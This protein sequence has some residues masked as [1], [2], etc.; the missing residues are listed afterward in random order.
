MADKKR[1]AKPGGVKAHPRLEDTKRIATREPVRE[2]HHDRNAPCPC[3]SGK[4]YKK[5]CADGPSLMTRV[6]AW[7]AR[8]MPGAKPRKADEPEKPAKA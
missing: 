7:L 2:E 5:C 4:K 6:K 1:I 3:G 8:L